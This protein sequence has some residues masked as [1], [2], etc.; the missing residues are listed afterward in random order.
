MLCVT[1]AVWF[2]VRGLSDGRTRW[3]VLSGVCV[4]LGFEAKMGAALLVVPAIAAAWLWVA[5]RG[6]A[7][8]LRQLG[9]G[10][11]AMA[12]VGLAWPVLVWLTPGVGPALDLGDERQQHLVAD[13]RLQRAGPADR[14]A[15]GARRRR[16]RRWRR[17]RRVRRRSG[18]AAAAEREPRRTGRL[19]ARV[20]G[21][22]PASALAGPDAAA[23]RRRAHRLADRCRRGV[24][25]DRGGVQPGLGDLPSVLR[26]AAGAVHGGAGRAPGSA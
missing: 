7:A 24:P 22:W 13:L 25:D 9:L 18:R 14:A 21:R 4:G 16:T 8:A 12:A 3:L 2:L 19:A 20:R 23:A 17:R 26:V 11:A 5:P 10:G 15:G 6:R 1:A